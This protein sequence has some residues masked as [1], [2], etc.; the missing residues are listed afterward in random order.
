MA[1]C[2]PSIKKVDEKTLFQE[3]RNNEEEIS[4]RLNDIRMNFKPE[5]GNWKSNKYY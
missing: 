1:C 5:Q 2:G 4:L 3:L